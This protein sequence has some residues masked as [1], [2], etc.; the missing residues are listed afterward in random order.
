MRRRIR[1][2][3]FTLLEVLVAT[4]IL[5]LSVAALLGALSQSMNNAAR[6][7]DY[8]RAAIAARAK[9]EELLLDPALPRFV[10]LSGALSHDQR[11]RA[12][13]VPFD[14]PPQPSPGYQVLDRIELTAS[15]KSGSQTKSITI[16]GYRP[17][18]LRAAD[19]AAPGALRQ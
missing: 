17:G 18:I 5:G 8:D 3:G 12:R 1:S 19:F 9:M 13:V 14:V 11:W 4:T 16:E 15:W 2:A 6:L 10:E 7:R